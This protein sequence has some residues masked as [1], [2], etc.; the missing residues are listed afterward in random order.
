M[1]RSMENLL[2]V[3]FRFA[4]VLVDDAVACHTFG[5][6]RSLGHDRIAWFAAS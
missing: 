2:D 6:R 4:N 1:L 3:L 5:S